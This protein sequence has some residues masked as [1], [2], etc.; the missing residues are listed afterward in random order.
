MPRT[1]VASVLSAN[2]KKEF[3]ANG[4]FMANLTAFDV[5]LNIDT[6]DYAV[7]GQDSNVS[8]QT[9]TSSRVVVTA[10]SVEGRD[11]WERVL[12]GI[13]PLS[14]GT[15]AAHPNQQAAVIIWENERNAENTEYV[16]SVFYGRWRPVAPSAPQGGPNDD[17]QAQFAGQAEVPV[18]FNGMYIDSE[19]VTLGS[20]GSNYTGTL[21]AAFD[22]TAKWSQSHLAII[23]RDNSSP[24][25]IE[26]LPYRD[27]AVSG[28]SVTITPEDL[29]GVSFTP[30]KALVV[31]IRRAQG[32]GVYP[33]SGK[34][35]SLWD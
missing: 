34:Q 31:G 22:T 16:R 29:V 32:A 8:K 4:V 2:R 27:G 1:T 25:K 13:D 24:P 30:T 7:Y 23:V 33:I 20:S 12:M 21:T 6:A 5:D 15:F 17:I 19:L 10:L 28:T 14:T 9:I 35:K 18:A 11:A 26:A 3:Y